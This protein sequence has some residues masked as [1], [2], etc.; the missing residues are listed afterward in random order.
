[1]EN[2]EL[3][4]EVKSVIISAVNLHHVDPTSIVA[5]TSLRDGGLGLDSIDMLEVVI[6][7]EQHFGVKVA[8]PEV[9]KRHFRTVGTIAE[10]IR[11]LKSAEA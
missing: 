9:G 1:M 2:T 5:T 6:A 4:T 10:F 8:D 3:A 11:N 7:I